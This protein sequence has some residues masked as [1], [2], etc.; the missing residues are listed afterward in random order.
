MLVFWEERLVVLATPKTGSTA[1]AALLA[2]YASVVLRG[3]PGLRHMGARGYARHVAPLL[4]A[5][6]AEG[7]ETF[8]LMRE[9][10][11][12]L[13]SWY[14]YRSR[15]E[16]AQTDRSTRGI[17]FD[18]FVA[19]WCAQPRP[20]FADVGQQSTFLAPEDAPA[21]RRIFRYEAMEAALAFLEARLERPLR[22][23]RLNVSPPNP[24]ALR[25]ETLQMLHHRHAAEF[26]L[27][28]RL[29]P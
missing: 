5:A 29:S 11:D 25:C 8:A 22:P 6:G 20:V 14:R 10:L 16:I 28:A 2:P 17:D 26:A 19:A 21:V 23:E 13:A 27:Y 9:P 15:A 4:A 7:F 12:W 18:G 3:P 24:V 1:L